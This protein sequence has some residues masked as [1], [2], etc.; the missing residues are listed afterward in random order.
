M[1][2][3]AITM[4]YDAL[5]GEFQT[6]ASAKFEQDSSKDGQLLLPSIVPWPWFHTPPLSFQILDVYFGQ[7][8][9]PCT[10]LL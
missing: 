1:D 5:V 6:E 3:Y 7:S 9:S 2:F 8:C 4:R 10:F